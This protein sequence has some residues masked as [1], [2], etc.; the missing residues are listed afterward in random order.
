MESL[1]SLAGVVVLAVPA[2]DAGVRDDMPAARNP[3]RAE[4]LSERLPRFRARTTQWHSDRAGP[5]AGWVSV[6]R[7]MES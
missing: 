6:A 5:T 1:L 2:L 4:E 3:V 7:E